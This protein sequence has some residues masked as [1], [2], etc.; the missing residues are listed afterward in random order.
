VLRRHRLRIAWGLS[1]TPVSSSGLH[2]VVSECC[3]QECGEVGHE[4]P[5]IRQ[6]VHDH[7][8]ISSDAKLQLHIGT[9]KSKTNSVQPCLSDTE[10]RKL[11][12]QSA[13]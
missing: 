9:M 6:S 8:N 2:D 3:L 13:G 10:K 11:K 7:I 5:H 12:C 4:V 1:G